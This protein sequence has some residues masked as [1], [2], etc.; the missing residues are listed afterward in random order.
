MKRNLWKKPWLWLFALYLGCNGMA[1][2]LPQFYA[3]CY[4][5]VVD[6]PAE[7]GEKLKAQTVSTDTLI[8]HF[9][10][11]RE[12]GYQP[13]SYQD[14]W[15][16]KE[17]RK[18]LPDKPVLLT[19]D[20]GYTSFY[21][22][23]LPLLKLY[24]YPAVLAVVGRWLQGGES[25][26]VDYGDKL[27]IPRS[28]F[29]SWSQ[30][31]E[32]ADSGWVEIASHSFDMHQGVLGNPF[33][34]LQPAALT[35]RFD[36]HE[37]SYETDSAFAQRIKADLAANQRLL[38]QKLGKSP[39]LMVWP[40][41]AYSRETQL[42]AQQQGLRTSLTLDG[43]GFNRLTD[44]RQIDRLLIKEEIRDVDLARYLRPP[45]KNPV[46]RVAHVDLDYLYDLDPIQQGRNLDQLLDRIKALNINTVF[47]QAFADPDGDGSADALYFPNRHLPMRADLFNRVAW[48]LRTRAGVS[49]YAWMPVLSF[50]GIKGA[51]F[52]ESS[53]DFGVPS[54]EGGYLRLSPFNEHNRR[55]IK[56][57][58]ADLAKHA[59]FNGLLFH[60]DAYLSDHE[61]VSESALA[62]YQER[63]QADLSV[64]QLR[65]KPELMQ[66]F[67]RHKTQA[68]IA[69][70]QELEQ[71]VVFYRGQ[72]LKTA[73][74]LYAR[75]V[76]EPQSEAWFAQN[77][78]D[79]VS[80]YDYT[81]VMAMPYMEGVRW[82]ATAWL[83]QLAASV[84]EQTP[85]LD[86]I[87]FELQ[88][89]D[90]RTGKP[91]GSK[92]L[93]RHMR[94]VNYAGIHSFGYYPEDFVKDYPEVDAIRPA[95]SLSWHPYRRK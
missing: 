25:A 68:L 31:K 88:T 43:Y 46:I 39:N 6:A 16:A 37:H 47:L 18:S 89:I 85:R 67:T 20:D 70:T 71:Q 22:H 24:K 1:Q 57:I 5:D 79:F 54:K 35:R 73:R 3:L 4:H 87:V 17:G 14:L 63:W 8:R 53:R 27:Q 72:S 93:K 40:Y 23:V 49:V 36:V 55:M 62:Y 77:L 28:H 66:A 78:G 41:G 10:W 33:N 56:E 2:A 64:A 86:K 65:A 69:F 92:K 7:Q 74:N 48:Q 9:N 44:L 26:V 50:S 90:W 76:L 52:V 11:L 60:D 82:R 21:T 84:K 91:I 94:A 58:Y 38:Q 13:V 80:A 19:F 59:H 42:I 30:L 95:L 29:L 51:T 32:I 12:H 45:D 83:N 15:A 75:T 81:A 34:N 61:D